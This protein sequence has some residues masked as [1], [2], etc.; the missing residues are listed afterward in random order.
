MDGFVKALTDFQDEYGQLKSNVAFENKSQKLII[1]ELQTQITNHKQDIETMKKHFSES[2][3][4]LEEELQSGHTL[5]IGLNNEIEQIM[6]RLDK[7]EELA[8]EELPQEPAKPAPATTETNL[9]LVDYV[10]KKKLRAQ[11]LI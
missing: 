6:R 3:D 1:Q 10:E 4:K 9:K 7:L 8:E 2:V 5:Q 11:G